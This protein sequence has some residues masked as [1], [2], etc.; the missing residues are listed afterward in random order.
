[1]IAVFWHFFFLESKAGL[2]PLANSIYLAGLLAARVALAAKLAFDTL[3][4]PL[5]AVALCIR[6]A[7]LVVIGVLDFD[8]FIMKLSFSHLLIDLA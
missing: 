5:L 1:M 7:A 8:L 3:P 6:A 4:F 2:S